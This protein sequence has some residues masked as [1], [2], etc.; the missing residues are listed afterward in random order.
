MKTYENP[1]IEIVALIP[2]DVVKTSEI[3]N[4]GTKP[5]S[6]DSLVSHIA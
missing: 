6:I 4:D 2:E 1:T 5:T 3:D